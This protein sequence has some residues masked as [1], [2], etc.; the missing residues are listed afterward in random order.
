MNPT[1]AVLWEGRS[2]LDGA[3]IV[4][5]VTGLRRPSENPKTGPMA[6]T[7]T[8]CRDQHP[9]RAALHNADRAICGDCPLRG[10][11]LRGRGCYVSL[12]SA[13]AAVWRAYR[14]GYYPRLSPDQVGN[15]I[16]RRGLRIG[17]YGDPAVV[18][19]D[20]WRQVARRCVP[21]VGYTHLWRTCDPEFKNLVMASC[22]TEADY[23]EAVA[24]GW[25]TFRVR[26]A[27][28][29]LLAGEKACP[30]ETKAL[31]CD[32]CGGC[33]G[34]NSRRPNFAIVAHGVHFAKP[35]VEK[36]L[37]HLAATQ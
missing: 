11:R 32:R 35:A 6:Q 13:P 18:P 15:A 36:L 22:Q 20:V 27:E 12:L 10:D 9:T 26:L 33:G 16:G 29:P 17:S 5:I 19:F 3:Y 14:R 28:Q 23:F 31:T 21:A 34:A 8:L 37:L 1:G 30:N 24:A 4:A 7:W 2:P 25:R